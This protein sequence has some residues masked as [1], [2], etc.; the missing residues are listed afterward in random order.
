MVPVGALLC[1]ARGRGQGSRSWERRL[2]ASCP[3]KINFG[4][5]SKHSKRL[6]DATEV[7]PP[8]RLNP[9]AHTCTEISNSG[10]KLLAA[11]GGPWTATASGVDLSLSS[12]PIN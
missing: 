1:K 7:P 5:A 9:T 2:D 11:K 6:P 3:L 8:L 12:Q 4:W 10:G